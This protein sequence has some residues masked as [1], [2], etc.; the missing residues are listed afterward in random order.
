MEDHNKN[1]NM[2]PVSI[3]IEF[4]NGNIWTTSNPL[5]LRKIGLTL[6]KNINWKFGAASDTL[7]N[8]YFL[9]LTELSKATKTGYTKVDLHEQMKP[10]IFKKFLDFPDFFTT[11]VPEYSTRN[12]TRKGWLAAIEQLKTVANDVFQYTFK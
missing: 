7:R 2:E 12:L 1:D 11:G 10:L 8:M 4:K 9:M 5:E 3:T 6:P